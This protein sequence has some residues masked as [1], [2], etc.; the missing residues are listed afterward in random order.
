MGMSDDNGRIWPALR[1]RTASYAEIAPAIAPAPRQ[2]TLARTGGAPVSFV[3]T[4]VAQA[5]SA[6]ERGP[7][8]RER[9]HTVTIYRTRTGKSW[10]VQVQY[11]TTWQHERD[12]TAVSIVRA[13]DEASAA[14][15]IGD[16]LRAYEPPDRDWAALITAVLGQ[17]PQATEVIQ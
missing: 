15:E 14:R 12:E 4:P 2:Y 13:P 6:P 7:K 3:G 9:W 16:I 11:R 10:I 8:G 1:G 5:V 17:L